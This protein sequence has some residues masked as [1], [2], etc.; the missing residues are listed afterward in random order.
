M[1][2]K[3]YYYSLA[4][5][6]DKVSSFEIGLRTKQR[7]VVTDLGHRDALLSLSKHKLAVQV[8]IE[9]SAE[10]VR[11]MGRF[12]SPII[13]IVLSINYQILPLIQLF[14]FCALW[15]RS[16]FPA[17]VKHMLSPLSDSNT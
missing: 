13:V 6:P 4:S 5:G 17:F 8:Y 2:R 3:F 7:I 14:G 16:A 12:D 9:F 1:Q 11:K 15:V 10:S